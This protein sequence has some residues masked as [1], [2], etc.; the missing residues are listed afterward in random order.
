LSRL[1]RE[2]RYRFTGKTM[3]GTDLNR[4]DE[5]GQTEL[6]VQERRTTSRVPF[7]AVAEIEAIDSGFRLTGRTTDLGRAGCFI[8]TLDPSSVA[9]GAIVRVVIKKEKLSFKTEAEVLYSQP[10]LGIGLLFTIVDPDHLWILEK[11][12]LKEAG[13]LK[14]PCG[15]SKVELQPDE[16][17]DPLARDVLEELIVMLGQTAVLSVPDALTLL[18]KLGR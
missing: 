2:P 6:A 9:V 17:F 7:I 13:E 1:V 8:D 3:E 18:R 10:G 11:W 12:V 14:A 4:P 16:K 15:P 5:V